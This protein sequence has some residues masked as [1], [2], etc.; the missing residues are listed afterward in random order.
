MVCV[1]RTNST[2]GHDLYT[3]NWKRILEAVKVPVLEK[4]EIQTDVVCIKSGIT[5][6]MAEKECAEMPDIIHGW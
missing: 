4:G 6:S 2:N 5:F 1:F 3:G